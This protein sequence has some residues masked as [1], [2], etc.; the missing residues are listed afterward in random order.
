MLAAF[1]HRFRILAGRLNLGLVNL[2]PEAGWDVPQLAAKRRLS[3]D[4]DLPARTSWQAYRARTGQIADLYERLASGHGKIL[5]APMVQA[6][7][8]GLAERCVNAV[9]KGVSHFDD[10]PLSTEGSRRVVPIVLTAILRSLDD[11]R[12]REALADSAG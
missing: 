8:D 12:L 6:L 4:P 9:A 1:E 10:D 5:V 2:I 3:G 7:C 11:G